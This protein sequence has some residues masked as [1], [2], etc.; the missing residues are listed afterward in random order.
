MASRNFLRLLPATVAAGLISSCA[1]MSGVGLERGWSDRYDI[2]L[3]WSREL[4]ADEG[5]Q[6]TEWFGILPVKLKYSHYAAGE[7]GEPLISDEDLFVG[8]STGHVFSFKLESGRLNW[9]IRPGKGAI[10]GKPGATGKELVVGTKTGWVL[11]FN[12][13]DGADLWAV[14]LPVAVAGPVA[15]VEN[16]AVVPTID[17]G[18]QAFDPANGNALWSI[19]GETP[20][21]GRPSIAGAAGVSAA[22]G[23]LLF[24]RW[25]ARISAADYSGRLLWTREV[26]KRATVSRGVDLYDTDFLLANDLGSSYFTIASRGIGRIRDDDG[27]VIWQKDLKATSGPAVDRYSRTVVAGNQDGELRAYSI[28]GEDRWVAEKFTFRACEWTDYL[29]MFVVFGLDCNQEPE[30][31]FGQPVAIKG[32][33][34]VPRSDGMIRFYDPETGRLVGELETSDELWSR[35]GS[36]VDQGYL[37][38][39]DNEGRL[40]V[41]QIERREP[42]KAD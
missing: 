30:G 13:Q 2:G 3:L 31:L 1:W 25:D 24:G 40:Y 28:E 15:I 32:L 41:I 10:A 35:L 8:T 33:F 12:K 22:D 19:P 14:Q 34:A 17:G 18:L 9:K 36:D 5:L 42:E 23:H 6:A 16:R 20:L 39:V 11:G 21:D 29:K 4:P 26:A 27:I 7:P 38:G 37:A